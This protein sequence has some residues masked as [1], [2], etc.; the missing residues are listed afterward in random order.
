[1]PKRTEG[2]PEDYVAH[3][4]AIASAIGGRISTRRRQLQLTQERLR[5][6]LELEQVYISRAEF[7][8]IERGEILPDAAEIIALMKVLQVSSN[9][10]LFGEEEAKQGMS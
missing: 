6:Q 4:R 3:R 7:S 2:V 1:M 10:L 8:R 9:W 5:A